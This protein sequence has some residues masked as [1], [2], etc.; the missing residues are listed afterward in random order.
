MS[1]LL[2]MEPRLAGTDVVEPAV[3]FEKHWDDLT[4]RAECPATVPHVTSPNC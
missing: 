1:T 2:E 4:E 3:D